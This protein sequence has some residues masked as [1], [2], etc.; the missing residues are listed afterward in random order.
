VHRGV[1]VREFALFVNPDV[2]TRWHRARVCITHAVAQ[3][4]Q[5]TALACAAI[6][7]SKGGNVTLRG[8]RR[9]SE[10]RFFR[11]SIVFAARA[12]ALGRLL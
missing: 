11:S 10:K 6:L 5:S 12:G 3:L 2:S 4:I 1:D 7:I 9:Q 8:M